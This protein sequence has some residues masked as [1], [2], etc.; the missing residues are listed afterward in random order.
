MDPLTIGMLAI[1]AVLIFFMFRNSR[2]RKADQEALLA[3]IVPGAEIMTNFGLFGTLKSVDEVTNVAEVETSP[4][5]IVRV[6]L[7]TIA[8]VVTADELDPSA[9]RSVEEA[10]A[11]ANREAEERD[12]VKLN[13]DSAIP[14]AEPA[15]GERIVTDEKK[16]SAKRTTKKTAE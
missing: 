6:H 16:P 11:I 1:L 7:Q 4:G 10:M 14:L 13:E 2:K 3:K 12:R 5:N 8:K 9:P 15:Y